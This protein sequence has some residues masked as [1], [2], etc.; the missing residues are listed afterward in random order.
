MTVAD[1]YLMRATPGQMAEFE[2]ISTIAKEVIPGM[3]IGLSYGVIAFKSG[4]KN[5]F[6]FGVYKK[7]MSLYPVFD[8]IGEVVGEE[9]QRRRVSKATLHFNET[10]PIPDSAIRAIIELL[11]AKYSK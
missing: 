2:R 6:Y 4:K 3:E 9:V 1:D 8:D 10:D 11:F 7:H 5:I